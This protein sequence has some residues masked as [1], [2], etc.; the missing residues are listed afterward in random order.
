MIEFK[1]YL[2]IALS[3]TH[4]LGPSSVDQSSYIFFYLFCPS[5]YYCLNIA[6]IHF[7]EYH[8]RLLEDDERHLFIQIHFKFPFND[9]S[10]LVSQLYRK[11][12]PFFSSFVINKANL[13]PVTTIQQS[14][15]EANLAK[16]VDYHLG[17]IMLIRG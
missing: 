1:A 13:L 12:I 4:Q 2:A 8:L 15:F 6:L 11:F 10:F 17:I 3:F 14:Y 5:R 9:L 16:H 7:R